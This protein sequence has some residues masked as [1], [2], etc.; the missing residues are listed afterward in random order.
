MMNS[1]IGDLSEGQKG[2]V[3]FAHLVLQEPGLMIL[4]EP[5]NHLD[6][7]S[8]EWLE[9]LLNAY[10]GAI[11]FITH[12]PEIA[13]LADEVLLLSEPLENMTGAA[14]MVD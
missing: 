13:A 8:I 12:D 7:D 5:T 3:A 14:G 9:G 11:I 6:L 10:T 1:Y 2:L 4:D